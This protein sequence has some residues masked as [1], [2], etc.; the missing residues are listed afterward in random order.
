MGWLG[1]GEKRSHDGVGGGEAAA[2]P[3]RELG[4][5]RCWERLPAGRLGL[6][7]GAGSGGHPGGQALRAF[8]AVGS[9]VR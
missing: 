1:R 9:V 8:A 4:P 6:I 2:A 5:C 7:L 3:Q